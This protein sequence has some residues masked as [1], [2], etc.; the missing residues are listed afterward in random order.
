MLRY[1]EPGKQPIEMCEQVKF[2]VQHGV[3]HIPDC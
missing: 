2:F 3:W 1:A